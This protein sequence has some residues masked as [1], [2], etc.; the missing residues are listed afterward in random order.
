MYTIDNWV[1]TKC[2]NLLGT[3]TNFKIALGVATLDFLATSILHKGA[4][5]LGY[6]VEEEEEEEEEEKKDW[7]YAAVIQAPLIE[8]MLF[9]I[10]G[11][12]LVGI[13]L[14]S[15]LSVLNSVGILPVF[16]SQK[17]V[18]SILVSLVVGRFFAKI[19]EDNYEK[20][21]ALVAN[22]TTPG[23]VALGVLREFYGFNHAVVAHAV[24]NLFVGLFDACFPTFLE[25]PKEKERRLQETKAAE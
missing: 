2:D 25:S 14:R 15:C 20:G 7:K 10:G 21:G 13:P 17:I 23:G 9:R 4:L 5:L 24:H 11:H 8:E 3:K 16:N 1:I 19:H 22:L 12:G 6:E 18:C